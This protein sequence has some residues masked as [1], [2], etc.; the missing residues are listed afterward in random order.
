MH[1][2]Q[3]KGEN[4]GLSPGQIQE[5]LQLSR[6]LSEQAWVDGRDVREV[7]QASAF[8]MMEKGRF[9]E[10]E[11]YDNAGEGQGR[12]VIKLD[13]W[14]DPDKYLFT[15]KH[16]A[17]TDGYYEW[18]VEKQVEPSG[19]VYHVC[20]GDARRCR[21][22]LPRGDRRE[23]IHLDRWRMLTP[24]TMLS[25]PYL[26]QRGR[27]LGEM[28]LKDY[29]ADLKEKA[30]KPAGDS[31]LQAAID[32]SIADAVDA[33]KKKPE[34]RGP[35][36][37][38]EAV[39]EKEE[40]GSR[41]RKHEDMGDY[42]R[43]QVMKR[44]PKDKEAG[45]K[46]EASRKEKKKKKRK[47]KKTSKSSSSESTSESQG[48]QSSLARGGN[49]VW[50]THLKYPGQLTQTALMEMSKYLSDRASVGDDPEIW[51]NQRVLGYLSQIFL[52]AHPQSK[53]GIRTVREMQTIATVLDLL[54]AGRLPQA[55]DLLVQRFKALEA[56]QG[57]GG[58]QMARHLELIP[59][60]S[61]GLMREEEREM[62]TKAELRSVKLKEALVRA[63]K[64]K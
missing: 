45:S 31:G 21:T 44:D 61:S 16:E 32:A 12:G 13:R 64:S 62:A 51:T 9:V 54:V 6:P 50:R 57:E 35:T 53:V 49:D 39:E 22:R 38:E 17:C 29:A 24:L 26:A 25:S 10:Y 4:L 56:A 11:C 7:S 27:E 23:L 2:L 15:G 37:E 3:R 8:E 14:E 48:F 60:N 59:L 33:A 41:K 55:T 20:S 63:Q 36:L 42:L 46:R 30:K 58:W 19:G 52:A 47:K 43:S 1:A 5:A 28:A 18:Y 40:R 34:A